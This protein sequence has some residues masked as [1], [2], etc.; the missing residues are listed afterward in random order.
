MEAT[1]TLTDGMHFDVKLGSGYRLDIDAAPESWGTGRGGRPMELLLAGLG[2]CTAVDVVSILRKARQEVT[3]FEVQVE[4]D[5]REEDPKVYTHIR[6]KYLIRGRN[7]SEDA[8]RRAINL[9]ETKY[10]SAS[11]MLGAVAK[12]EFSYH[13]LQEP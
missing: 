8:V 2:G 11:A 1:V 9:S 13:L 12:I 3:G 7:L 6:V 5:R 4:G 10:C